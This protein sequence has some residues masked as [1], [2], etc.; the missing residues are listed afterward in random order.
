MRF[1][2]ALLVALG[3]CSTPVFAS[4][5][6]PPPAE[7]SHHSILDA[8]KS[9]AHTI[10]DLAADTSLLSPETPNALRALSASYLALNVM[11][12]GTT[13]AALGKNIGTEQNVLMS[14]LASHPTAFLLTKLA[15]TG[16]TLYLTE[17]L[18]K[19][20]PVL[21]YT[22]LVAVNSTMVAVVAHNQSVL[23]PSAW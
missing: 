21:A 19:R 6:D 14:G 3:V 22:V 5:E 15:T 7:T 17:R 18:R 8:L 1:A 13:T 12:W 4:D 9:S 11:D 20:S 2:C 23:H 10:G 16:T